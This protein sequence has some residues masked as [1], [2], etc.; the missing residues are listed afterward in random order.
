VNSRTVTWALGALA[1]ALTVA[2]A[3]SLWHRQPATDTAQPAPSSQTQSTADPTGPATE[4][5]AENGPTAL[6][7]SE[8]EA[9]DASPGATP[10]SQNDEARGNWAPVATGFGKAFTATH[11]KS[12]A[13][14]RDNLAPFVTGTVE[15]QLAT[16]ALANVPD[17][18][19]DSIEP[20]EYGDDKVAVFVHYNTDLTLVT[21]LILDG[22][23]WHIYAYD[24]WE[25]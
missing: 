13:Q 21:Y 17:G 3:V 5:A 10:Y 14:W 16:V 1:L 11:G 25:E 9:H 12:A 2:L 7:S 23:D 24:R 19:F 15:D 18:T 6:P 4:P 8:V 22:T 20:A